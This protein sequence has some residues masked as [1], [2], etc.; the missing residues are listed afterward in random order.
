MYTNK[1]GKLKGKNQIC[2]PKWQKTNKQINKQTKQNEWKKF[3]NTIPTLSSLSR[4]QMVHFFGRI[5]GTYSERILQLPRIVMSFLWLTHK[6][7]SKSNGKEYFISFSLLVTLF[8]CFQGYNILLRITFKSWKAN[9]LSSGQVL[10]VCWFSSFLSVHKNI[11]PPKMKHACLK[12]STLKWTSIFQI[13]QILQTVQTD[14][15]TKCFDIKVVFFWFSL[16][17]AYLFIAEK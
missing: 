10:P 3:L 15:Y 14:R 16:N 12:R 7:S 9:P 5:E 11:F 8:V 13:N 6:M 4:S 2:H 17:S 1:Q